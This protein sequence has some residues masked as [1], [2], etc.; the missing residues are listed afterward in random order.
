[1]STMSAKPVP[2]AAEMFAE[3]IIISGINVA[4]LKMFKRTAVCISY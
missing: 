1:M 3:D 2:L 4:H